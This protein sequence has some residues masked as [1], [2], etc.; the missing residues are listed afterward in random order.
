MHDC[1]GLVI[2]ILHTI[3]SSNIYYPQYFR[4]YMQ[5]SGPMSY[6][7]ASHTLSAEGSGAGAVSP[8]FVD[9]RVR[10]PSAS[11]HH[12]P[13]RSPYN[14]PNSHIPSPHLIYSGSRRLES[15]L[16]PLHSF[17]VGIAVTLSQTL[18]LESHRSAMLGKISSLCVIEYQ[19]DREIGGCNGG[20]Y[21][22]TLWHW[23]SSR[24]GRLEAAML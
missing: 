20:K 7:F 14:P 24:G 6:T 19:A 9:S 2:F 11:N 12:L 21:L 22:I 15:L 3:I 4:P 13:R 8:K 10:I 17:Y 23:M 1:L 16:I 5:Q 18:D